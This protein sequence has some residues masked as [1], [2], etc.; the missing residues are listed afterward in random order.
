MAHWIIVGVA[1]WLALQLPLGMYIGR[2][3]AARNAEESTLA[4]AT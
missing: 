1:L 4:L 3:L 2:R